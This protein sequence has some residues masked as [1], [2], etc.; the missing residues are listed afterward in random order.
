MGD[1][2]RRPAATRNHNP[3]KSLSADSRG[4]IDGGTRYTNRRD[5]GEL[6][7]R[8]AIVPR[9]FRS[10]CNGSFWPDHRSFLIPYAQGLVA[11]AELRETRAQ[12]G[13]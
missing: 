7:N 9:E 4:N 11:K 10:H 8:H 3:V 12:V 6:M 5:R 13:S 1:K 2:L